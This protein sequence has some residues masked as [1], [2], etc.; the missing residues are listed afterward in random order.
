MGDTVPAVIRRLATAAVF[1]SLAACSAASSS[2]EP[3]ATVASGRT[4]SSAASSPTRTSPPS[5]APS[6]TRP[7][8]PTMI[9]VR[10]TLKIEDNGDGT[11]TLR[12]KSNLPDGTEL[13]SFVGQ[14]PSGSPKRYYGYKGQAHATMHAGVAE[15]GPFSDKGSP[16][17][18]GR[19][20]VSVTMPIAINQPDDV[21]AVIG[22]HGEYLTGP[23][24]KQVYGSAKV[25]VDKKLTID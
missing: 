24:V 4:P 8:K 3:V 5:S 20:D 17:P 13:G 2:P 1:L 10:M 21:K 23:L 14:E 25:N 18:A 19:Y 22:E 12:A 9:R 7:A 16:L 11:V 6:S 15:F